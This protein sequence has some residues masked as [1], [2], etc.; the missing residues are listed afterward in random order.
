MSPRLAFALESLER[1]GRLTLEYFRAGTT[2]ETKGDKTPVTIAD[3]EAEA[4]LREAIGRAYPGETILGEE[5]GLA[6]GSGEGR[7]VIDPIDG[8]KSF[9]CGVPLYANLL[10]YEIDDEP[11]LAACC[12]PALGEMIW[13]ERGQGSFLNERP[14]RVSTRTSL[15]GAVICTAS[16]FGLRRRGVLEQVVA[17]SERA[18]ATRTW[19][20]AY[21]HAMVARGAADAMIDPSVARWDI[22]A[23]SLIVR[24]AG[25]RFTDF[26]GGDALGA[27]GLSSNG[28]LHES[29]LEVLR[30]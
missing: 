23:M 18:L 28:L 6:S 14:I 2:V 11:A 16:V 29:V 17:L 7:W 30:K 21:G 25:G 3:R 20:D 26:S 13:A 1:A 15:E 24:E 27:E 19:C 5:Q 12:F 9:I 22:S 4:L 10:S 8:T